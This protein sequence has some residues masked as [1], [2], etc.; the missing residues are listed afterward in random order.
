MELLT[1]GQ[2]SEDLH[3]KNEGLKTSSENKINRFVP[4]QSS[5]EDIN[6]EDLVENFANE[7]EVDAME[8]MELSSGNTFLKRWF[9]K[10]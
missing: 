4:A 5:E 8:L 10:S 1:Q 7:G 6:P 2:L 3:E 9:S